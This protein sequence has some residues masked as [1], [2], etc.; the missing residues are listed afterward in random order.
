MRRIQVVA[1][2]PSLAERTE[3]ERLELALSF[4]QQESNQIKKSLKVS[5]EILKFI[6]NQNYPGNVGQMKSDIQLICAEGYLHS[7]TKNLKTISI[8]YNL[9]ED[10]KL[11]P[12][13]ADADE[14]REEIFFIPGD[15]SIPADSLLQL[16]KSSKQLDPFYSLLLKEYKELQSSNLSHQDISAFLREKIQS[17]FDY[18]FQQKNVARILEYDNPMHYKIDNVVSHIEKSL[19]LS[20]TK[21]KKNILINH[22][23]SLI[24]IVKNTP[25]DSLFLF[26]KGLVINKLDYFEEVKNIC[27]HIEETFQLNCPPVE[28]SFMSLF[29]QRLLHEDNTT[30]RKYDNDIIIIAHGESTAPV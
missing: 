22:I 25:A 14:Q 7:M 23:Y 19:Q 17:H 12:A 16:P 18:T 30:E 10:K 29:L 24:S 13:S 9:I 5:E 3:K 1:Q 20:F 27:T 8:D 26:D 2:I 28:L 6:A 15:P 21:L 4:F 11:L